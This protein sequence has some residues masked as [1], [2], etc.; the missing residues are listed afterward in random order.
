M[1][2]AALPSD[3]HHQQMFSSVILIEWLRLTRLHYRIS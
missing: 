1:T 3:D 2:R